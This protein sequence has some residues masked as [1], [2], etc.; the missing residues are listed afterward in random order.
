MALSLGP[1]ALRPG[2]LKGTIMRPFITLAT[3]LALIAG[4]APALAENGTSPRENAPT[5][6]VAFGDLDLGSA[7]GVRRLSRRIALAT[8][9]VCGSY[10][11][12]SDAENHAISECRRDLRASLEAQLA[13]RLGQ[14]LARYARTESR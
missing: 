4:A 14:G 3:S 13:R 12:A 11:G 5:R 1:G 10:A 2:C 7:A 6:S 8:E 9:A